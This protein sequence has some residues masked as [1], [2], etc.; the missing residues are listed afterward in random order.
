MGLAASAL[1]ISCVKNEVSVTQRNMAEAAN[2]TEVTIRNRCKELR[3][4]NIEV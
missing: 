3:R 4:L 1:Y 2:V